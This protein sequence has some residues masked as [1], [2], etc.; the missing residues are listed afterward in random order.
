M[1]GV[2]PAANGYYI[3]KSRLLPPRLDVIGYAERVDWDSLVSQL[4]AVTR[5]QGAVVK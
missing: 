5:S 2:A 3:V 1:D 4:I